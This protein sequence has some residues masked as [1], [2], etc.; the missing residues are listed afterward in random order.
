[1]ALG[2]KI[3]PNLA[4]VGLAAALVAGTLLVTGSASSL[5]QE[6]GASGAEPGHQHPMV[7][8][9]KMGGQTP[10]RGPRPLAQLA[11]GKR[12]LYNTVSPGTHE[13][14][15]YQLVL[16]NGATA[17]AVAVNVIIMDHANQANSPV[18]QEQLQ[19]AAGEKRTLNTE[20][21][22]G[23]ANHFR[24]SV[25]AQNADLTFEVTIRNA[26]GEEAAR[27]N[28]RAFL[29]QDLTAGRPGGH[30]GGENMPK[31]GPHMPGQ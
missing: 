22:Y 14:D 20:N 25:A 31:H 9:D 17:Q 27:Y 1:M 11:A 28:Q 24:T 21:G 30:K 12:V 7:G 16:T 15:Q 8:K 19:L 13:G 29:V 5:A 3:G 6:L 4:V 18:L 23:Q 26:S 10:A 2:R